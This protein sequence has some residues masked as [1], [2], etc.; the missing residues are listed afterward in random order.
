MFGNS[1]WFI[2]GIVQQVL[3]I[4]L[5]RTAGIGVQ[6]RK[7]ASRPANQRL[8]RSAEEIEDAERE[9][10]QE[11]DDAIEEIAEHLFM[12]GQVER[13]QIR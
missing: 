6:T 10:A 7:T 12:E 4:S 5:F 1:F 9:K 3:C 11:N 13:L 2:R 8:H